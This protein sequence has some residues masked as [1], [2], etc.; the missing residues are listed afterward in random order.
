MTNEVGLGLVA[1]HR[2]GRIF[3]DLLGTVNQAVARA[4]DE[5][6]LMVAGRPLRL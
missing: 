3:T 4:S 5:V 6:V 2:S 1:E